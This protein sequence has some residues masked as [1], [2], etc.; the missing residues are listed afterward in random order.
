M[1]TIVKWNF[2]IPYKVKVSLNIIT[3]VV[4]YNLICISLD[5]CSVQVCALLYILDCR[6]GGRGWAGWA[7]A[8]PI[9]WIKKRISQ[10][11]FDYR[12]CCQQY[13]LTH[14]NSSS[15]RQPCMYYVTDRQ[16]IW[17]KSAAFF[18]K[19]KRLVFLLILTLFTLSHSSTRPDNIVAHCQS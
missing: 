5:K 14:P 12:H 17:K 6:A 7:F 4:V 3:T 13:V 2:L 9:I 10:P 19:R 16:T 1:I 15:F 11:F 8:Y 18:P